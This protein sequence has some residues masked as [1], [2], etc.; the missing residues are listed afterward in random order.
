MLGDRHVSLEDKM[1]GCGWSVTRDVEFMLGNDFCN[2]VLH[3]L[4]LGEHQ[5][6]SSALSGLWGSKNSEVS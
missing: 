1:E 4:G 2:S 6:C 3:L 5:F